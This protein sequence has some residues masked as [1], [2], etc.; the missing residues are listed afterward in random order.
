VLLHRPEVYEA[1]PPDEMR[2][3]AELIIAKHRNGPTG[4]VK[5]Q[6]FDSTMRFENR[7]PMVEPVAP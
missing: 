5:L 6:F 2:G 7:S 4:L 3:L 1:E